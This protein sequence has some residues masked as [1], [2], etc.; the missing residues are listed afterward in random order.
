MKI[1]FLK[2]ICIHNNT[3]GGFW[4]PTAC[5]LVVQSKVLRGK[6]CHP[7]DPGFRLAK[8]LEF[9][10]EYDISLRKEVK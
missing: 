7:L 4:K 8:A 3:N 9:L 1:I 10:R 2:K 6:Y 5:F